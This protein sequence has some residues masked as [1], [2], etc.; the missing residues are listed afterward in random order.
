MMRAILISLLHGI[1]D[2]ATYHAFDVPE[3]YLPTGYDPK[4]ADQYDLDD[5]DWTGLAY[6][7]G[8]VRGTINPTQK[9]FYIEFMA[10]TLTRQVA[11]VLRHAIDQFQDVNEFVFEINPNG[12]T[13]GYYTAKNV[14]VM[15]PRDALRIVQQ[16]IGQPR[17]G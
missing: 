9:R 8:W 10:G 12:P 2:D 4:T 13:L 6:E 11:M 1:H 5:V 17:R 14:T 7:H 16:N 15:E 3:E